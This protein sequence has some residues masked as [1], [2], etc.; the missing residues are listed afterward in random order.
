MDECEELKQ[1][2]RYYGSLS[3]T[4]LITIKDLICFMLTVKSKEVMGPAAVSSFTVKSATKVTLQIKPSM[5]EKSPRCRKFS[6]IIA[7]MDS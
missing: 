1:I 2:I 4:K 3:E 5:K 6:T 7:H